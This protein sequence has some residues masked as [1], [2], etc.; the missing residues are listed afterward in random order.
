MTILGQHGYAK[1][2]KIQQGIEDGSIQGVIM[3]PRDERPQNLVSFLSQLPHWVERLVDPQFYVGA[4]SNP[5][6]GKLDDYS[7]Y[8]TN[9]APAS[10][11]PAAITR[12]VDDTLEWQDALNVS[13]VVSPTVIVDALSN[14]WAQIAMTMAQESLYRHSSERPLLI[15]L[16]IGEDA[17]L[18]T[19]LVDAWLNELTQLDVA[20]FYLVVRRSQEDY[21]QQYDPEILSSLLRVCYSLAQVNEYKVIVGY[22][23]LVTLLLHAVGVEGTGAGWYASLRQFGLRRF[24]QVTGGS[25]PRPRYTSRPLLNSIFIFELN[26]I[27]NN[28]YIANVL[29]DTN[30]DQPFNGNQNPGNVSWPPRDAAL[31]HWR[32]LSDIAE[33]ISGTTVSARLDS[34]R[35]SIGQALALYT[36]IG[37]DLFRTETGPTHLQ[38][39]LDA[40]DRFRS[41]AQV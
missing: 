5:R 11:T 22:S 41:D 3:S 28:G 33:S 35:S 37:L 19:T 38:Q 23:D 14:R 18:E 25:Q 36:Q 2:D 16:V 4:I 6:Q 32:V 30:Y 29:S 17:L 26:S 39:W 9:L 20:G 34:V 24:S 12:Y 40:L 13:M 15:S 31:H 8:A 7:H 10:F 27:Y 21:R 1:S